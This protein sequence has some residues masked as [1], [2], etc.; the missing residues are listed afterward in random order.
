MAKRPATSPTPV[1]EITALPWTPPLGSP[2]VVGRC[3]F[4][5]TVTYFVVGRLVAV[6][7]DE[8]LFES[9]SWVA[10]TGRFHDAIKTGKLNEVEPFTDPVIVGRG[11]V[12][13]A[14][15]RRHELPTKQK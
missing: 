13:D 12:V 10:D 5:R 8:L 14:T 7:A 9:A 3:Y 1:P 4:V 6:Y 15:A 11:A 2:W